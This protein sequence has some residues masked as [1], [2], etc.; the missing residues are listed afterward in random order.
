MKALATVIFVIAIA[1]L[2]TGSAQGQS[3]EYPIRFQ[4]PFDFQVAEKTF[5]AGEYFVSRV[6][7]PSSAAALLISSVDG[8]HTTIRLTSP[9]QT[10][11]VKKRGTLVFHRYGDQ[12][13]LFEVWPAGAQ[14][15]RVLPKSRTERELQKSQEVA[16]TPIR[17]SPAVETVNV[18]GGPR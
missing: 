16:G 18:V 8:R 5:P 6:L 17:T 12:H 2:T 15:G 4:I 9:V 1:I 3:L 10:L 13:F 14:T 11:A 7:Q